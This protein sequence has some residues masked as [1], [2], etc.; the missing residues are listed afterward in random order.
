MLGKLSVCLALLT[1]Y[2]GTTGASEKTRQIDSLLNITE[3]YEFADAKSGVC[4]H[5]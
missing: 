2:W 3:K 5:Y 4:G 1:W